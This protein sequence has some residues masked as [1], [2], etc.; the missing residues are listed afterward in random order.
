MPPQRDRIG[1]DSVILDDEGRPQWGV[2]NETDICLADQGLAERQF[3]HGMSNHQ[4]HWRPWHLDEQHQPTAWAGRM[5]DRIINR[6]DPTR[7]AV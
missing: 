3:D 7:P 6:H 2:L 5:M 4:Y 1:F